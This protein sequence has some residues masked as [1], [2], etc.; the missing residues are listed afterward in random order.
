M[1]RLALSLDL[2]SKTSLLQNEDLPCNLRFCLNKMKTTMLRVLIKCPS[3]NATCSRTW[4]AERALMGSIT[5]TPR[6][7]PSQPSLSMTGSF[8]FRRQNDALAS[9]RPMP[10]MSAFLNPSLSWPSSVTSKFVRIYC[11]QLP[12][13]KNAPGPTT[14]FY[15]DPHR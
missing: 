12:A 3:N 4:R 1:I 2:V 6:V 15:L 9:H 14:L 5:Q 8:L 7:A 13:P 10:L 11:K